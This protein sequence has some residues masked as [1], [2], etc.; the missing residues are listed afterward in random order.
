MTRREY[1]IQILGAHMAMRRAA[2]MAGLP[3]AIL[4]TGA[5]VWMFLLAK[6]DPTKFPQ[7]AAFALPIC[8]AA[9]VAHSLYIGRTFAR[10]SPVCPSCS[11]H[12]RILQRRR[13]WASGKCVYCNGQIV[14]P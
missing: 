7:F 11:R 4:S 1:V 2:L 10:T 13:V 9:M 12:V 6:S 3:V 8:L 5:T 14:E